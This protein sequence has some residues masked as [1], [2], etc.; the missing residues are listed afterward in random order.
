MQ[1]DMT[2]PDWTKLREQFPTLRNW[3][4]LDTARKMMPPLCQER[5]LRAYWSDVTENLGAQAWSANGV[6]QARERL[7]QMLGAKITE[8]AFTKN[9][10]EGLCIA[11]NGLDLRPGDNIVLTNMEHIANLWVWKHWET[12]GVEIRYAE[13]IDWRLPLDAFLAKMDAR[14][15][16]V[17]TAYVTYGNGYRVDLPALGAVCRERGVLLVVDGIQAAGVLAKPV[18][19]L[20]A[21]IVAIGGH[22]NL[23][24][25]T[26][27]GIVW[28]REELVNE[29]KT[30]FVR[31]AVPFETDE[32]R[33]ARALEPEYMRAAHRFEGG[34]FNFLGVSVLRS[35]AE[36]IQSIGLEK[37][38]ARVRYLTTYCMD[39]LA[40][41]RLK[42]RTPGEWSQR[43][44][45]ISVPVNDALALVATLRDKYRVIANAKDSAVRLSLSFA[46]NEEDIDR[47]VHALA[48]E[49]PSGS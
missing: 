38:E 8:I 23:F 42:T 19:E 13:H 30:P 20:G 2:H 15:R 1:F 24:G 26:G 16:I 45:I 35:G 46:N 31:V 29:L 6:A 25:L 32:T 43:A 11:S 41:R 47:A 18:A 22:K 5:A 34:N 39:R 27:S 40:K 33:A 44:Q 12:K 9:T 7:A 14:T 17:S 4:Y 48:S 10:S 28:C 36:F 21:D 49:V 37:I 3:T